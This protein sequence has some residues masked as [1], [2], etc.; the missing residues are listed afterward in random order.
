MPGGQPPFAPAASA[1]AGLRIPHKKGPRV[2]IEEPKVTRA[3][4]AA[5][6]KSLAAKHESVARRLAEL[7]SA[8]VAFSGGVDSTLLLAIAREELGERVL[9]VTASSETYPPEELETARECAAGLGAR[10]EVV[11]TGELG[12]ARFSANPADRCFYCKADLFRE[13]EEI[14]IREDYAAIVDGSN[15]D[16]SRDFRPG[17]AAAREADVLSPLA[18]AGLTKEEVRRLARELSLSTADKPAMAC[19]ASRIPYGTPITSQRLASV[20]RAERA[21]SALGFRTVRVR[22]HGDVARVELPPDELERALASRDA[23]AEAV[24]RAGFAYVALDL[25]GYRMGSMNE[26]LGGRE[27]QP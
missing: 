20:A 18:E 15:A 4:L 16:D 7:G 21:L 12:D 5:A 10:F 11:Q 23:I 14:R 19:L 17:R 24:T 2:T 6:P 22:H 26:V 13:L 27:P 1:S 9:A 3:Q 8:V 25:V